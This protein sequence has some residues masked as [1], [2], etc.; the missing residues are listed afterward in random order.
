MNHVEPLAEQPA[1]PPISNAP[2]PLL[3]FTERVNVPGHDAR[4]AEK[5]QAPGPDPLPPR[6][7]MISIEV[8]PG[9]GPL[10]WRGERDPSMTSVCIPRF[11]FAAT[12][13]LRARRGG[14]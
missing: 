4:G 9:G 12:G 1:P 3:N 5:A 8:H 14:R 6:P 13:C 11:V 10:T 2:S 7:G